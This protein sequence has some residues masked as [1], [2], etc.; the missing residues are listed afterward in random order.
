M[1]HRQLEADREVVRTT[2]KPSRAS[3]E[4][5]TNDGKVKFAR[6]EQAT[7]SPN[8]PE[9]GGREYVFRWSSWKQS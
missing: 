6:S 7:T 3:C 5:E 2:A 8:H 4:K 9:E 1:S